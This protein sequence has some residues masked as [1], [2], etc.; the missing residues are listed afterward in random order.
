MTRPALPPEWLSRRTPTF[1]FPKSLLRPLLRT[2]RSLKDSGW[3]PAVPLQQHVVICGFPR[4]GTT[5]FQLMMEGCIEGPGCRG[6]EIRAMDLAACGRRSHAAL[7]SKR[8]KDLFLIPE[9]REFYA[10]RGV[11][12]QFVLLH[13]DPRSVLTSKHFSRPAEYYLSAEEWRHYYAHWNWHRG[14]PDV[15]S[16][17]YEDLVRDPDQVEQRV[18]EFTGWQAR[19]RFRDFVQHVPRGFDGRALNALRELDPSRLTAWRGEQH[20]RRLRELLTELPELPER[21]VGMG[22]EPD[23]GWLRLLQ[24]DASSGIVA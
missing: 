3:L 7:V 22:F 4:S 12:L 17:S 5:L 8:P 6:R 14:D 2:V 16:V 1:Q 23:D 19:W 21:L 18:L 10:G 9:L 11:R 24:D 20:V 15:L 13:R